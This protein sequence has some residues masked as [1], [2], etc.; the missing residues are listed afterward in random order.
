M[1][2]EKVSSS[3]RFSKKN[4]A[5]IPANKDMGPIIYF[6]FERLKTDFIKEDAINVKTVITTKSDIIQIESK[7]DSKWLT[8]SKIDIFFTAAKYGRKTLEVSPELKEPIVMIS[9][10]IDIEETKNK[11]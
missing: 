11:P 7:T 8:T 2:D 1:L 9:K 4:N 6:E 10:S 5:P 3:K